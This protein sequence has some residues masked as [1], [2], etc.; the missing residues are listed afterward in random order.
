MKKNIYIVAALAGMF[1]MNSC[2][3]DDLLPGNP[4]MDFKTEYSDALFGDSLPFTIKATDVDVPLSTLKAQLYFDGEKVS[5]TV[6]R[7]KTS[8]EDYTGKIYIPYLANI[9]NGKATLKYI[10]QNIN[11]TT[12]EK[13][14]ELSLSRPDFP[15]LT[16]ITEDAKEYKMERNE[17][18]Q[19]SVTDR[20]SNEVKGY[21]VSPKVG[22]N[23]NVITFGWS[24][25]E[26]TQGS[27]SSI[28]FSNATAGKYSITFNTF[29]YVGS[30]FMNLGVNGEKME[31]AD[32][33]SFRIDLNL[34]KGQKL[35]FEGVP[36]YD[37]WWIDPDFFKKDDDGKLEFLP[38]SGN[39]RIIANMKHKT[40]FVQALL[41]GKLATTQPDGTGAIWI[42]GNGVGKP[43]VAAREVGWTPDNA[44][45]MSQMEP[46]KYQATFV[47]GRSIKSSGIDFKF[48]YAAGWDG[49]FKGDALTSNSNLIGV[50]TGKVDG[51]GYDSGNLYLKEGKTLTPGHIYKLVVDVTAGIDKAV[52][53]VTDQGEQ[54]IEIKNITMGG[55]K[56]NSVD[57]E[58][59]TAIMDLTQNQSIAVSGISG[60]NEW[61]INPDYMTLEDGSLKFLPLA[62]KY[63]ITANTSAR[64]IAVSRMNG[65]EDATLGADGHGAIW[66]MGWGVGSPSLDKQLDWNPGT[67]Y[68]MPEVAPKIYR[69]TAT[70]GPEKGSLIGDRIRFDYLS[71][72]FFFQN[73]WGG[74]LAG[75][76]ALTIAAGSEAYISQPGNIELA[77]DV[78]L[79]IGSTYVITVD[80]TA[81]NNKG[82]VSF[83]KK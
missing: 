25:K 15:Y 11:F 48:F 3:D 74:E 82:I 2:K 19:Y 7:T 1:L 52:L 56:M 29:S 55:Q 62:G 42:I 41:N 59:Y 51:V 64:H 44:L 58:I 80:L 30:P 63:K 73:G 27:T 81:G 33:E 26:I 43:S 16:L 36:D 21:I 71:C 60:L 34:T 39:Y 5:E 67:A 14:V 68:C 9:P 18:Y 8:G 24:G 32:S 54:T 79:E 57:G 50:G 65:N 17:L 83:A 46:K 23:G 66:M 20:F 4:V 6:I 53:S 10:L 28:S 76:N 35:A 12:S 45:C 49:E 69:F 38:I 37:N 75:D 70:A 72:K 13:V 31:L 22:E 77:K 47:A 40:F 61:W 78:K